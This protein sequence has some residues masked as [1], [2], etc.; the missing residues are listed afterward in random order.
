MAS[1]MDL[2]SATPK[3]VSREVRLDRRPSSA[4]VL[5]WALRG[6]SELG[7]W[8]L[9]AQKAVATTTAGRRP[10]ISPTFSGTYKRL[11]PPSGGISVRHQGR[12]PA[13]VAPSADSEAH[14]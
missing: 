9:S 6:S 11:A 12:S 3:D 4:R 8:A 1:I 13:A 2:P 10:I 7:R 14:H 5:A